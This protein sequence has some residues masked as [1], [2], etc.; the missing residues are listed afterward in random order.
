MWRPGR[1]SICALRQRV[2][3]HAKAAAEAIKLSRR[4]HTYPP[5]IVSIAYCDY[6]FLDGK[7]EDLNE[8]MVRR[9]T[10]LN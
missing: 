5:A 1:R 2:R 8:R 7:W 3:W 9:C 10:E 4:M 6:T